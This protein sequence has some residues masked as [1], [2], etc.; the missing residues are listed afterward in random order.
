MILGFDSIPI[1]PL[2]KGNTDDSKPNHLKKS[3]IK[4]L[5]FAMIQAVKIAICI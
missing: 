4:Y 5:H 1:R 3:Y 2:K